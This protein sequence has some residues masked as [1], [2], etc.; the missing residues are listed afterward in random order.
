MNII[1]QEEQTIH[2][3]AIPVVYIYF[4]IATSFFSDEAHEQRYVVAGPFLNKTIFTNN[5]R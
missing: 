1:V 2:F 3:Y 5:K 4:H